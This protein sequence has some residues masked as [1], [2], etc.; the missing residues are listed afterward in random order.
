MGGRMSGESPREEKVE[1]FAGSPGD[2]SANHESITADT[3]TPMF[4]GHRSR[5]QL[6]VRWPFGQHDS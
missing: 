5:Q 3:V 4:E 1:D 6:I 2:E